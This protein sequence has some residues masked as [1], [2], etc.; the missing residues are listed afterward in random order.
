LDTVARSEMVE[1][2]LDAMIRRRDERR[3]TEEGDRAAEEM[4]RES[5]QRHEAQQREQNRTAWLDYHRA[6]AERARRNLEALVARHEAAA[7]MVENG[8]RESA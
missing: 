4:W 6:A 1:K 5:V 8:Y 3:R 2:E 7:E